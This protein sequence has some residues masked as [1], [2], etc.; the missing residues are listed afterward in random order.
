MV[1]HMQVFGVPDPRVGE[2]ICVYLRVR[3]GIQLSEADI[4]QYC[5][6]KVRGSSVLHD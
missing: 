5:R 3:A 4:V 1:Y 6:E 2:E